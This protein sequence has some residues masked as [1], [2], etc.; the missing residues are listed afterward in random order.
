[1]I[2]VKDKET[3]N[4]ILNKLNI[5]D[6][7]FYYEYFEIY[8]TNY[9][10]DLEAVY[11]EDENVII[12]FPHLVRNIKNIPLFKELKEDYYDLTTPY[13]YGGP[14]VKIKVD[15]ENKIKESIKKFKLE[16]YKYALSRNYVCEFIRFHPILENHKYFCEIFNVEYIN[17]IVYIDLTQSL[18]EIWKNMN[19]LTK[20][21]IKKS[22][23]FCPI[24][25][26]VTSPEDIHIKDFLN[27]YYK[28]MDRHGAEKK[29]Y[30]GKQFILD[31][32][33]KLGGIFILVKD[34]KNITASIALFVGSKENL[35]YHLGA[36]NYEIAKKYKISPLR[37]VLWVAIKYAKEKNFRHLILGGGRISND[38]LFKFKL[39]FSKKTKPF[40]IG[41]IVFNKKVYETLS[42]L[43]KINK[44]EKFFPAYRKNFDETIV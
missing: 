8:K 33:R 2:T 28:T 29:Y 12:F 20:R 25:Q 14:V 43:A 42:N 41:E 17:D 5:N 10:V 30:F 21:S 9:N 26:I 24:V 19:N 38:S 22:Q 27:L 23:K 40:Y 39:G 11:W 31:H 6:I 35:Y 1:M 4:R 18:D 32:L 37:L 15:K 13:G 16:Y 36:T 34:I 44:E 3:W 7:F